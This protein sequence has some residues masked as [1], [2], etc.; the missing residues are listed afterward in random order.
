MNR[1]EKVEKAVCSESSYKKLK[2][3]E[4]QPPELMSPRSISHMADQKQFPA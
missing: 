1:F 4:L 3:T 2:V